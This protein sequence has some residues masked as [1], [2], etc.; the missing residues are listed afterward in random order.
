MGG[1]HITSPSLSLT[2]SS[3][4]RPVH[5]STFTGMPSPFSAQAY[6]PL[7]WRKPR[8]DSITGHT[9]DAMPG[10]H[11]AEERLG[12]G[13]A[14][15]ELWPRRGTPAPRQADGPPQGT[16][17]RGP[18]KL[19]RLAAPPHPARREAQPGH[20]APEYLPPVP[21]LRC[22]GSASS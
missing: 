1:H 2:A 4:A 5:L 22:A 14:E 7:R 16:S 21:P 20:R 8:R 18:G 6:G 11:L 15:P 9:R 3:Q 19:M 13:L 12:P 10:L 17:L